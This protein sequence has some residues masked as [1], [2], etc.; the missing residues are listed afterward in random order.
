MDV[1]KILAALRQDRAQIEEAVM[2]LQ[3]LARSGRRRRD[4]SPAARLKTKSDEPNEGSG[5]T[6]GEGCAGVPCV[7][8]ARRPR[9]APP[10]NCRTRR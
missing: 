9:R 6:P 2:S 7:Y 4:C 5:G 1:T 10:R 3:H 8:L